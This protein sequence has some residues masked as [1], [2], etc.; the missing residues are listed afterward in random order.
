MRVFEDIPH[1]EPVIL[2][3][4]AE[5]GWWYSISLPDGRIAIALNTDCDLLP[6][7]RE[8]REA[9][10]QNAIENTRYT[11]ELSRVHKSGASGVVVSPAHTALLRSGIGR[12]W[13]A[14]GDA[15]A[16][17]DPLSS[18]GIFH[19]LESGHLAGLAIDADLSGDET[20]L[21]RYAS[22][23]EGAF[24]RY[25]QHRWTQYYREERWQAAVFWSR[26]RHWAE[27]AITDEKANVLESM[28]LA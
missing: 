7:R 14:V 4:S 28:V 6:H 21:R 26:R 5:G 16:T 10:W 13:L 25:M 23:V 18:G 12:R 1:T 9:F 11:L 17:R 2:T 15:Y 24:S 20:A 19:A 8:D 27:G 22:A 3:E